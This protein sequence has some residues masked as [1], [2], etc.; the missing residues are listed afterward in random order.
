LPLRAVDAAVEARAELPH[1]SSK[2]EALHAHLDSNPTVV[3]I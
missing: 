2:A 3:R 1:A